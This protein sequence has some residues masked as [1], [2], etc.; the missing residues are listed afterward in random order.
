MNLFIFNFLNGFA[1]GY[2]ALDSTF[3]FMG[4]GFPYV[5]IIILGYFL[6]TH[7]DKKRG[8]QEVLMMVGV[9]IL[10]WFLA[11]YF[12]GVFDTQR[13][14]VAIPGV[15]QLFPQE[16]DGAFPS[17]HA[18]FFSALA[19]MMWFYHRRIA[20]SL[21]VVAII[22]GLGRVISGVHFPIDILGGYVLGFL[23]SVISYFAIQWFLK[24]RES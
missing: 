11:H 3:A 24:N 9:A 12:K 4:N 19:V 14:F 8:V 23:I 22:V 15:S 13:P 18:T 1:V 2:P 6:L 10:A 20:L 21:G 17:G 5:A 16:A 7:E